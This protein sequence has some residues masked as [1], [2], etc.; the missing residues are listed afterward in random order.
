MVTIG[1][2]RRRAACARPTACSAC[3][4]S[5]VACEAVRCACWSYPLCQSPRNDCRMSAGSMPRVSSAMLS[6]YV[7]KNQS[8]A[9]MAEIAPISQASWPYAEG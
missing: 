5:G 8:R 4:A 6:R 1:S 3:V 2:W 7:G 9:S